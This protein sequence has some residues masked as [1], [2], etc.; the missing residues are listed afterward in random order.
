MTYYTIWM[1]IKGFQPGRGLNF[2]RFPWVEL[3]LTR[4]EV[5]SEAE[6]VL[7]YY[8]DSDPAREFI[9]CRH[10]IGLIGLDDYEEGGD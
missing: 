2:F 7:L 10:T 6:K 8:R 4:F 9:I 3:P 5:Y 1:R